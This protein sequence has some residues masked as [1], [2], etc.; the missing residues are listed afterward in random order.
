MTISLLTTRP[1]SLNAFNDELV[2][3]KK[4]L[5]G[6]LLNSWRANTLAR[7]RALFRLATGICPLDVTTLRAMKAHPEQG[8]NYALTWLT[9]RF[10]SEQRAALA[11]IQ[12]PRGPA[13]YHLTS[14]GPPAPLSVDCPPLADL[15]FPEAEAR[16]PLEVA[17]LLTTLNHRFLA[18]P[19]DGPLPPDLPGPPPGGKN[20]SPFTP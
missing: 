10:T 5:R 4:T 13:W 2:Q 14:S 11:L 1:D 18:R 16:R 6:P 19:G 15:P 9:S 8:V 3:Q 20:P 17:R 7:R 12:T